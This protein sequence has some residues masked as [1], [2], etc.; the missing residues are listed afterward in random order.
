MLAAIRRRRTDRRA[1]GMFDAIDELTDSVAEVG[2]KLDVG[3]T[4]LGSE[5]RAGLLRATQASAAARRYDSEYQAELH[6]WAGHSMSSGGIPETSL[7]SGGGSVPIARTFPARRNAAMGDQGA[8]DESTVVAIGTTTDSRRDWLR[9]GQVLSSILL[10]ATVRGA[11][12]CP[13]SHMTEVPGS[14]ALLNRLV[15]EVGV[16]QML[17]RIGRAPGG[18]PPVMTTR[19]SMSEV[20]TVT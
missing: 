14:R 4:V 18:T 6:W 10:E 1:F 16:P 2:R 5:Q 19:R 17:V 13:L 9:C 11:A 7:V 3:V 8:I 15:P 20:L 12:T